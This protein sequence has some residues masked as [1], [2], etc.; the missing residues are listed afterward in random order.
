MELKLKTLLETRVEVEKHF[1][2]FEL[3]K[4]LHEVRVEDEVENTS[5]RSSWSFM[6]FELELKLK[7]LHEV[8]KDVGL[9]IFFSLLVLITK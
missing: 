6:K 3:K 1:M 5:R 4:T 7:T 8:G 2:K 9:I